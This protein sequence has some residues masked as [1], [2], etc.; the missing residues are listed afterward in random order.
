M[1]PLRTERLVIRVMQPTDAATVAAYRS[2]PAVAEFQDWP[3]PYSEQMAAERLAA[4][5]GR[6]TSELLAAGTNLAIEADGALIG[7][8][9]VR[10]DDALAEVGWTLRRAAQGKGYATEAAA[11]VVGLLFT[12]LGAHRVEAGM[13]PDNVAS[14]RVCEAIGMTFEARTR[15]SFRGRDGWEDDVRYAMLRDEWEAWVGRPRHRPREVGLVELG[16]DNVGRFRRLTTHRSQ[17][18]LVAPMAASFEDALF[19]EVIDG[20]PVVPWMRGIEADEQ[21]VGFVMLASATAHHPE[22]YLWRLLVDRMHQRRG[23]GEMALEAVCAGLRADGHA[24]L[25]TSW[26]DAPGGPR[27]FYERLGFVPTGRIVDGEI[28]ARLTL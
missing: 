19:P 12:R 23:I 14:A 25:L 4:T 18:Q 24:S 2:D 28:E 22:P 9:Y 3:L 26:V 15:M 27:P 5:P 16:P 1:L 20:A 8:V 7:D 17:E 21:P 10:L 6:D 11:A 13:H